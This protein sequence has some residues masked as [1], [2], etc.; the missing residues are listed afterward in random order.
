MQHPDASPYAR[1][2]RDLPLHPRLRTYFSTIPDDHIGI[3]E[4][5][6]HRVGARRRWVRALLQPLHRRGVVAAVWARDVPFQV[7]NRT[8]AGRAVARRELDLPG[9]AWVMHD[10]VALSPGGHLVD[11]IGAPRTVAAM[12][13]AHAE[14]GALVLA[15]QAVGI[16]L[17]R[18]RLRV[19]RWCSPVVRLRESYDEANDRQR[20]DLV[21]RLPLIGT[22][23]EYS[24][25]FTYRI[26][27]EQP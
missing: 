12:F 22:V 10:A 14:D 26:E 13:E 25:S 2:L 27:K 3:G 21:L 18:C 6:F 16:R 20:V 17:G 23:Y 24:G 1:A 11:E 5:V 8:V 4:G 15:S 19:P 9:G 7:I